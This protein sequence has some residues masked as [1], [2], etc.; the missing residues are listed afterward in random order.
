MARHWPEEIDHL[1]HDAA[2]RSRL[3]IEIANSQS[4]EIV[5]HI[6]EPL[7]LALEPLDAV[8]GS[9]FALG[10]GRIKLLGKKFQI[11][12][13]GGKVIFDFV[14]EPARRDSAR[15]T[16]RNWSPLQFD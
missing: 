4:K 16:S 2:E 5:G 8:G 7:A 12:T 15:S 11:Q 14:Y 3:Q 6:H 9:S 1:F 10:F 13:K